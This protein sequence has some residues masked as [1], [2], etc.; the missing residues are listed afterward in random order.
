[1]PDHGNIYIIDPDGRVVQITEGPF[2]DQR[3]CFSPDGSRIVFVSNRNGGLTLWSV[4]VSGE[5][6]P[7]PLPYQ[8]S[9]HRPWFSK[10]GQAI[11]FIAGVDDLSEERG[12]HHICQVGLRDSEANPLL[13]DDH[14]RSHGPFADP[15]GKMLLMHSTRGRD[16]E[17]STGGIHHHSIWELPLDGSSPCKIDIPG[18]ADPM[19]GTRS[20]NGV[21]A[22][23]T[24]TKH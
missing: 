13:N 14:G 24:I 19:H 21:L 20:R 1:M 9:A 10:D 15:N 12:R 5:S 6:D 3:P 7:E 18:V 17:T 11:V 22:F 4:P 8:G 16:K 23:D 2:V